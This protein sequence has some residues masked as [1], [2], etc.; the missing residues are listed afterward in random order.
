M[1]LGQ[2][3]NFTCKLRGH[4]VV[5]NVARVSVDCGIQRRAAHKIPRRI[6]LANTEHS[7][8]KNLVVHRSSVSES[9]A[10]MLA[11]ASE[12]GQKNVSMSTDRCHVLNAITMPFLAARRKTS[13]SHH[14]S[15]QHHNICGQSYRRLHGWAN[16]LP[17][18]YY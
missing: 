16:L 14:C 11:P 4:M 8:S 5:P 12:V 6:Y 17:V 2:V 3:L 10:D 15:L 13:N 18:K 9:Q 1:V 7:S